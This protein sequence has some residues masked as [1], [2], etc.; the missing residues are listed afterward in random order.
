MVEDDDETRAALVRELTARGYRT[1]EAADGATALERWE[2]R[3]P[4]VVLLD[5]G[6][7]DMD[8]LDDRPPDPPRGARR[9]S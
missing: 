1:E 5:L 7:P 2:A 8:G 4:D 6:L 9:R 3:R